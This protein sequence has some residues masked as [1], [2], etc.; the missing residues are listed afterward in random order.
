[1][2]FWD[3]GQFLRWLGNTPD[4]AEHVNWGIIDPDGT[5]K[6]LLRQGWIVS[7]KDWFRATCNNANTGHSEYGP[8][9]S[10]F[11]RNSILNRKHAWISRWNGSVSLAEGGVGLD[12][13][14]ST[15][16]C[17]FEFGLDFKARD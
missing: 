11:E 9:L 6:H 5:G 7:N 16:K 10:R 8:R 3:Y 4:E 17:T 1:M 2:S 13:S 12:K 14:S 15:C